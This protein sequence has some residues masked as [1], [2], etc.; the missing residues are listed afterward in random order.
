MLP[1]LLL[2][3]PALPALPTLPPFPA[4]PVIPPSPLALF[5]NGQFSSLL[6]A[7]RALAR[8]V[9]SALPALPALPSFL[10][11]PLFHPHFW[12]CVKNEQ[13]LAF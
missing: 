6:N 8:A 11:L 12:L 10:L 3:C 7:C 13:F 1:Y 4:P 2:S 9:L 5:E